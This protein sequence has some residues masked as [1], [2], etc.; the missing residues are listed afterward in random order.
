MGSTP[1]RYSRPPFRAPWTRTSAATAAAPADETGAQHAEVG[2]AGEWEA[3]RDR[4]RVAHPRHRRRAGDDHQE[5]RHGQGHQR[6]EH[7]EPGPAEDD[8]DDQGADPGGDRGRVARAQT[9][10]H[11]PGLGQG[12]RAICR[13]ADQVR[14]LAQHHVAGDAAEEPE[15]DRVGHEA[16]V[17]TEPDH[18]LRALVAG[19]RREPEPAARAAALVVVTTI[20]RVELVSPPATGPANDAWSPWA[21]GSKTRVT[22]HG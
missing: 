5:G 18:G 1:D 19:V 12:D 8:E 15:H 17:A 4:S 7:R 16:D 9:G 22:R 21:G 13:D 6:G 11:V 2:D 20:R 3:V 14:R 10:H